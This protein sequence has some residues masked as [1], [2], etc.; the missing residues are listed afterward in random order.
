MTSLR[1]LICRSLVFI[2]SLGFLAIVLPS[3]AHAA[4]CG[5]TNIRWASSSN[6][7][8]LSGPVTCTLSEIKAIRPTAPL[9]LV[10]SSNKTW[11]LRSNLVIEKGAKLVLHGS[12]IGGDVNELR[13]KSN[14]DSSATSIVW[15]RAQWG[16]IDIANTKITSWDAVANG[17]DTE[18]SAYKRA[19]IR[20]RSF[21]E[22]DG[23]TARESRMDIRAS[24]IAYLGYYAAESYGLV[25]KVSGT[26]AG[27]FDKVNVYGDVTD[28][29]L[30]H[31]YFG[32]YTYGAY[33]M[34]I[35]GNEVNN[36]VQYGIDP[37]DDSDYLT[38]ENNNSHDN[39]THGIICSQR[40]DH[41]T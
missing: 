21:L 15:V 27:R 22:S 8:Y 7:L 24:E 9:D 4:T 20:V 2:I 35:T 32:M 40:C 1:N 41:L 30:H 36:S 19:F 12:A 14:N 39:G 31:N 13:L 5:L 37:H 3:K 23:L 25:W 29:H 33:G 17:P 10:D 6:T 28:S 34:Q 11:Y 26:T 18:Y 38:I 16:T